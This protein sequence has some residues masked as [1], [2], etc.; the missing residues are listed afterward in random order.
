MGYTATLLVLLVSSCATTHTIVVPADKQI[1]WA[2][3]GTT[4]TNGAWQVSDSTMI[5]ILEKL[6][7]VR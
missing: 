6:H 1:W 5:E 4:I 7:G 2:A 3:A